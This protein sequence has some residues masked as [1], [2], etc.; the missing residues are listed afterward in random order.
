MHSLR[1]YK[2]HFLL[3]LL[4][5]I[6]AGGAYVVQQ[7]GW[8]DKAGKTAEQD[9]PGLYSI[10]HFIDGDTIAVNMNGQAESVRFIGV[11][12]PETHKPNTPVQCYGPAAAAFTKNTIGSSKVRLES[13]PL[14][15]NRDRYNRL[16][17]YVYLPDGTLLNEKLIQ[18]GYGFYYPYFPFSKSKQFAADEQTAM[19]ARKGLWAN[20]H[21][22]PT[23]DGGYVS[24]NQ[25]T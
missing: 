7:Q 15:T 25:G 4:A 20:C 17:R 2:R 23:D 1:Y 18:Q 19:A 24:N 22:M 12:T 5:L 10:N 9:Q 14:S 16:L 6:I 13:D 11:D 8:L 21:P 3:G